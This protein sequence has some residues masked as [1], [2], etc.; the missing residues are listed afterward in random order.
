MPKLR[1]LHVLAAAI[2]IYDDALGPP[3]YTSWS[4]LARMVGGIR[5]CGVRPVKS[6]PGVFRRGPSIDSRSHLLIRG[7]AAS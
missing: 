3:G 2:V 5:A 4:G 7:S 6:A 1:A